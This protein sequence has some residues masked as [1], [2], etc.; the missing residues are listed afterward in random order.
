MFV[1]LCNGNNDV[2]LHYGVKRTDSIGEIAKVEQKHEKN[3]EL[4]EIDLEGGLRE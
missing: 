1:D 2:V 4:D 3:F